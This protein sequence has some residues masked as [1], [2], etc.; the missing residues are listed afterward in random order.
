MRKNFF[1]WMNEELVECDFLFVVFV[2]Y[3]I[4]IIYLV[5]MFDSLSWFSF[6]CVYNDVCLY[7]GFFLLIFLNVLF[8]GVLLRMIIRS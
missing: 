5:G 4:R 2:I 7:V 6:E 8:C 1:Y 3:V